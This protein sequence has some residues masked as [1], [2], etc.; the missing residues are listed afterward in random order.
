MVDC[1]TKFQCILVILVSSRKFLFVLL[2]SITQFINGVFSVSP[3]VLA[4]S[5]L[6]SSRI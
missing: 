1:V 3:D 6:F 2:L 5:R 4:I